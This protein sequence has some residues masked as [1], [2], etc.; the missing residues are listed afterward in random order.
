MDQTADMAEAEG[1]EK[2]QEKEMGGGEE[3]DLQTQPE[4]DADR[5]FEWFYMPSPHQQRKHILRATDTAA[6][7]TNAQNAL[8]WTLLHVRLL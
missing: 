4:L 5:L 7:P 2:V 8:G 3:E 1:G 6:L